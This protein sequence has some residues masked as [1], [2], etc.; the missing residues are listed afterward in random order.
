MT[1]LSLGVGGLVAG[2]TLRLGPCPSAPPQPPPRS[3]S[4]PRRDKACSGDFVQTEQTLRQPMVWSRR[5]R[6]EPGKPERSWRWGWQGKGPGVGTGLV[7]PGPEGSGQCGRWW[8]VLQPLDGVEQ[9]WPGLSV[10]PACAAHVTLRSGC[11]VRA[12]GSPGSGQPR[13]GDDK[14]GPTS[15]LG[16]PHLPEKAS[17]DGEAVTALQLKA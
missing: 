9:G 3:W 10:L 16:L 17:R 13:G 6:H 1:S 2:R 4:G 14:A 12:A 5:P 11:C 15:R 8:R 7:R